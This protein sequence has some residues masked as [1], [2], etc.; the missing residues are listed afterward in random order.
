MKLC[1]LQTDIIWNAPG[2]NIAAADGQFVAHPGA[3]LYVLPEMWCTGFQTEPDAATATAGRRALDWMATTSAALGTA[4]A[5]SVPLAA[6]DGTFTNTLVVAQH[7]H[8]VTYDKRH[9]FTYG[10][11]NRH[12]SPGQ[13]RVV[14]EVCGWRILLQVCYDLRFPVFAR[15]QGGDY[16]ILL[17]VA[18]WPASRRTVWDV[19]LRARAIENQCYAIGVNRVGTDPTCTYDGGTTLI[20]PRG[21]LLATATDGAAGA[22]CHELTADDRAALRRFRQKFPVLADADRFTLDI[23]PTTPQP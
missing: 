2:D 16:D 23:T 17:Y 21:Q 19:L 14:V 8:T 22:I 12:Y 7:G 5:G 20:S 9:L 18:N 4:I 10:G 6:A 11:E 3:D 1:L 15:S 13:R